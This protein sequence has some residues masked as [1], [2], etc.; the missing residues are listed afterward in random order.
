VEASAEGLIAEATQRMSWA[1][2]LKR[3]FRLDI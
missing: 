1:V 2:C 3:A